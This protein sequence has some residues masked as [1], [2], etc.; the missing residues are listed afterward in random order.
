MNFLEQFMVVTV[1]IAI[2]S[3]TL[4]LMAC[5]LA[6]IQ[7]LGRLMYTGG[8][9]NFGPKGRFAGGLLTM[10]S[11]PVAMVGGFYTIAVWNNKMVYQVPS[12]NSSALF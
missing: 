5:I 2:T 8:Y 6:W 10:G 4:P 1:M 11:T 9:H 12:G 3:L 7:V